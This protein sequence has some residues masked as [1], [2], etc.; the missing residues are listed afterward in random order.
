MLDRSEIEFALFN[1]GWI[2]LDKIDALND[3]LLRWKSRE[4][5]SFFQRGSS[6]VREHLETLP[7]IG[8]PRSVQVDETCQ[9]MAYNYVIFSEGIRVHL[10]GGEVYPLEVIRMEGERGLGTRGME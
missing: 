8:Y 4:G 1:D 2:K 6:P 10:R 3:I 7:S 9:R 5:Y